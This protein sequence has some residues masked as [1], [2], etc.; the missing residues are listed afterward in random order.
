MAATGIGN[1]GSPKKNLAAG[2]SPSS[3]PGRPENVQPTDLPSSEVGDE[4]IAHLAYQLWELAGC[5]EKQSE[6]HWLEAERQLRS[7]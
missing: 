3:A 7:R 6:L 2:A 1:P 5:P 4:E